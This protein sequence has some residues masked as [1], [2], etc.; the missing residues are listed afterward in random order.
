M[1][2]ICDADKDNFNDACDQLNCD[3]GIDDETDMVNVNVMLPYFEYMI[4]KSKR[5]YL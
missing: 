4:D 5:R 3:E 2:S 1:F